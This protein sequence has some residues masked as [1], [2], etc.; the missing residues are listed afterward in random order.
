L[1]AIIVL[2]LDALELFV[3]HGGLLMKFFSLSLE[4]VY[5]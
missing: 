1:L 5:F 2:Q 3:E 4:I